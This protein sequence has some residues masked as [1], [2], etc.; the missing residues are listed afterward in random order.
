MPG[1][2]V[3]VGGAGFAWAGLVDTGP[4][5]LN[6]D[7]SITN[8]D[9]TVTNADGSVSPTNLANTGQNGQW[10]V[11][12]VLGTQLIATGLLLMWLRRKGIR[13]AQR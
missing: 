1:T 9:G 4:G 5:T 3:P 8:A 11:V 13:R 2:V 12:G 7:G 6:P 10:Y